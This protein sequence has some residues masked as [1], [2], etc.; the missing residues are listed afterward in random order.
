[1]PPLCLYLEL[2]SL[3]DDKYQIVVRLPSGETI[4]AVAVNRIR[5]HEINVCFEILSHYKHSITPLEESKI[6]RQFGQKLFNFLIGDHPPVY[7][8]YINVLGGLQGIRLALALENA[9]QLAHL[10]WEL[11]RDPERDFLALSSS[12]SVVR[13]APH[14]VVSS[15]VPVILPLRVLVITATRNG[16][17]DW[18]Q[19][20]EA[21]AALQQYG[22]LKLDRLH[23]TSKSSLRLHLLAEDY[24]VI[25]YVGVSQ[26]S[27][28]A[29]LTT[30]DLNHEY[31]PESTVRLLVAQHTSITAATRN[32]F[33]AFATL[34][35]PIGRPATTLFLRE[36]YGALLRV[37]TVDSAI[38][39][40][41]RAIANQFQTGEWASSVLVTH[42]QTGVLFR[43]VFDAGAFPKQPT[44]R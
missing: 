17:Q 7:N 8:A 42:P 34:Q 43:P 3:P 28:T 26:P 30:D 5:S 38:S 37:V 27:P 24:H 36:F 35:F 22:H 4:R 1:M 14:L 11:L 44:A 18:R 9:G 39:H 15:S 25:H 13:T 41:R 10:P 20:S 23:P 32:V 40:A 6:I 31:Y 2:T 29:A 33:P 21:T 16:E 12:V 19:L